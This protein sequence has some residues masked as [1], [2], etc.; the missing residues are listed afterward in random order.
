MGINK[1]KSFTTKIQT[2]NNYKL[3]SLKQLSNFSFYT[4]NIMSKLIIL[5]LCGTARD[6]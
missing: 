4:S 3:K 2:H 5:K 1:K 6:V